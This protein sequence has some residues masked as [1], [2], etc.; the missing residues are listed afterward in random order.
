MLSDKNTLIVIGGP[1]GSGKTLFAIRLARAINASIISADSRQVFRE[2]KIGSAAPSEDELALA[3]HYFV[4]SHGITDSFSAGIFAEQSLTLLQEKLFRQNPIQIVCGGSG[5]YINA[6]IRGLDEM[7][8]I[9]DFIRE[10]VNTK[11]KMHGI[12]YLQEQIKV[13]DPAYFEEVDPSNPRRL[14]RAL[15]V[16]QHTGKPYSFFRKKRT[17]RP[18]FEVIFYALSP[19]RE[20]LYANINQRTHSMIE[21]GWIEE[22][23]KLTAHQHLNALQTVGYKEI[24]AY[25]QQQRDLDQ[26]ISMIQ[27][28]TRRFAK[29]QITWFRGQEDVRWI[30]PSVELEELGIS[31]W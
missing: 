19:S 26:T 14:Q 7:P 16:I 4:G 29:R 25:F 15:E 30:H 22:T 18:P 31:N 6:L 23:R 24:F 3:P 20:E 28:N 10:D 21:K 11:F 1:T 9:P 27:Q 17:C 8:D 12:E 2:L 5:L 13:K